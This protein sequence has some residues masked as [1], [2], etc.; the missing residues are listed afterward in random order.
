MAL[1]MFFLVVSLF[2]VILNP[3]INWL[4]Q[5]NSEV[6]I[7]QQA[8]LSIASRTLKLAPI[9][10]SGPGTFSY[11]FSKFKSPSFS[12]SSLW[13]ITFNKSSSKVLNNLATTGALGLLALLALMVFP[14][15]YGIKFFVGKKENSGA[16]KTEKSSNQIYSILLLGLLVAL[17]EESIAYFVYNS[18]ITLDFVYFFVIAAII[19]LVSQ[20]KKEYAL[21]SSPLLTLAT[22][23]VFILVF[24][25]GMG[26]L[27]LDGQRYA[28]EVNYNKGLAD[29]Q[30]GHKADGLKKLELAITLNSGSDLYYAQLSQAYLLN[31]QDELQ[32]SKSTALSDAEKTKIQTLISNSVNAGKIST[33]I[34]PRDSNNWSS[35]GYVY[36]SLAGVLP[37]ASTWAIN[38]YDS[39][40]KLDPNNPYLFLQEGNVYL[41]EAESS[42]SVSA[43]QKNTFLMQAQKQLEKAVA[44]N[45]NYSDALYSLGIVYDYL[46]QEDKAL[47]TFTA[48][49]QLNP[50]NTDISA[51]L[52]KLKAGKSAFQINA[53]PADNP[54]AGALK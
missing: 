6:S 34:N 29:Y 10:G 11:D 3:Q 49:Q 43:D 52:A 48:L 44:L 18:N 21:K 5:K 19:G 45:P 38:S 14:I 12:A 47:N 15:F 41:A 16:D 53:P 35:R 4:P 17:V 33:D 51:I 50:T 22:T 27:I 24:I 1:P 2:F 28:A 46:G 8:G 36:Q 9:L 31:L 20:N 32:N 42:P 30:A 37:D 40:L 39:A 26:I 25:F 7:T 23:F 13:N 54:T